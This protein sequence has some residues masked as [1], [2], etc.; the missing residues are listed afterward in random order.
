MGFKDFDQ[1]IT[2]FHTNKQLENVSFSRSIE[3]DI[4]QIFDFNVKEVETEIKEIRML[5]RKD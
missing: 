1:G 4:I 3:P 2:V 5:L